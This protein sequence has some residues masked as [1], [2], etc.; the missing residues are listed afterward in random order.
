MGEQSDHQR[1]PITHPITL[2]SDERQ[3]EKKYPTRP[4]ECL[5]S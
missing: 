2:I 1:K 4:R 5:R 3:R